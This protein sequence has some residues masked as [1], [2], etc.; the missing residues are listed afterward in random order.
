MQYGDSY[1]DQPRSSVDIVSVVDR[2]SSALSS[3]LLSSGIGSAAAARAESARDKSASAQP[4]EALLSSSEQSNMSPKLHARNTLLLNRSQ[5][6][7]VFQPEHHAGTSASTTNMLPPLPVGVDGLDLKAVG[8]FNSTDTTPPLPENDNGLALPVLRSQRNGQP[9]TPNHHFDLAGIVTYANNASHDSSPLTSPQHSTSHQAESILSLDGARHT[10]LSVLSIAQQLHEHEITDNAGFQ[11]PQIEYESIH[12]TRVSFSDAF[13]MRLTEHDRQWRSGRQGTSWGF[14]NLNIEIRSKVFQAILAKYC[15]TAD[16][17]DDWLL[18]LNLLYTCRGVRGE[19][20]GPYTSTVSGLPL[21]FDFNDSTS[22]L[23]YVRWLHAFGARLQYVEQVLHE[24]E[25]DNSGKARALKM[26]F[27][28][29]S[30]GNVSI[31]VYCKCREGSMPCRSE[32]QHDDWLARKEGVEGM[33]DN[34]VTNIH[35]LSM[36]DIITDFGGYFGRQTSLYGFMVVQQPHEMPK[37]RD[38]Q[39][40]AR[41]K[42]HGVSPTALTP[43]AEPHAPKKKGDSY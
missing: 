7:A 26:T 30:V 14:L 38:A 5:H 18:A 33:T 28:R 20:G 15:K 19:F 12:S 24:Q 37:L 25:V 36:A 2:S 9:Q 17:Q 43:L 6:I 8:S 16:K 34:E 3:D 22:R 35:T 23:G 13:T 21:K 29:L 40:T 42:L 39:W 1:P 27:R 32:Q 4:D 10:D 31:E 11:E 41:G